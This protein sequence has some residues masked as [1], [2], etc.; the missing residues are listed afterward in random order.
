MLQCLQ[1]HTSIN[2]NDPNPS[3]FIDVFVATLVS[4]FQRR[5]IKCIA[6]NFCK[7]CRRNRQDTS[8]PSLT[9]DELIS[10]GMQEWQKF[11]SLKMTLAFK[12]KRLFRFL[13]ALVGKLRV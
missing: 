10:C 5:D 11:A 6:L 8:C 2:P 12:L 13:L 9:Q 4:Y 3:C 7:E 1:R